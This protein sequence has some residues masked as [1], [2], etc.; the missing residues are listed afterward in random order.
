MIVKIII[1]FLRNFIKGETK[2]FAFMMQGGYYA[3][4][5]FVAFFYFLKVKEYENVMDLVY[6]NGW[7]VVIFA[8]FV[9]GELIAK[10][11]TLIYKKN[12]KPIQ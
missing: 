7:L 6:F 1:S 10:I 9:T 4:L 12:D 8:G 11:I 3:F 5:N 2:K